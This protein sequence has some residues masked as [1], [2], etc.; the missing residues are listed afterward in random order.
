[1]IFLAQ[2]LHALERQSNLQPVTVAV[3]RAVLVVAGLRGVGVV[4]L[5]TRPCRS[6]IHPV[7]AREHA[8]DR[9]AVGAAAASAKRDGPGRE[10]LG[11]LIL[12]PLMMLVVLLYVLPIQDPVLR[13][14]ALLTCSMPMMGIYPIL[15]QKHG[16]DGLSAAT[17]LVTTMASFFSLN[18][19]L[20]VLKD[21]N[22]I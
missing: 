8:P 6:E 5:L 14:A 2:R 20:W 10:R 19:M 16:H 12:H 15:T 9:D 4:A 7:I 18:A 3:S 17:L 22:L 1:M 21:L 13:I 11:K